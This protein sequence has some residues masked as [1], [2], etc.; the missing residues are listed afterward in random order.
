MNL[1]TIVL[2]GLGGFLGAVLRFLVYEVSFK[3]SSFLAN[4]TNMQFISLLATLFV[5]IVGS[6]ALGFLFAYIQNEEFS[7]LSK[8][9]L[10]SFF[11][12]GLLG[13]FTTF[14]TFSYGNWLLLQNG[15]YGQL[16]LNILCNVG[17]C[18]LA[19]C[20]GFAIYKISG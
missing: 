13:A 11:G 12:V 7:L 10:M 8:D 1:Y 6:F 15:L 3:I 14:S 4:V 19:V 20:G 16:L 17:L 9:V 2:V 18:L 5:N